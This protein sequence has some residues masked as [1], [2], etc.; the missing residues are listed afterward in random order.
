MLTL[1]LTI[2]NGPVLYWALDSSHNGRNPAV[3]FSLPPKAMQRSEASFG[4]PLTDDLLTFWRANKT[5]S[6]WVE[7]TEELPN[8]TFHTWWKGPISGTS[9]SADLLRLNITSSSAQLTRKAQVARLPKLR[10]NEL[11][12]DTNPE[13]PDRQESLP[14]IYGTV[15]GLPVLLASDPNYTEN[16]VFVIAGHPITSETVT[17]I[18]DGNYLGSYAVQTA[19]GSKGEYSYVQVPKSILG[20]QQSGLYLEQVTGKR[21]TIPDLLQ[22]LANQ[23]LPGEHKQEWRDM[24]TSGYA[25][26]YLKS[27]SLGMFLNQEITGD[28]LTAIGQ[29]LSQ[30]FPI[31][32]GFP[33]GKFSWCYTGVTMAPAIDDLQPLIYGQDLWNRSDLNGI[34]F[35]QVRNNFVYTAGFDGGTGREKLQRVL[36]RT[37]SAFCRVSAGVWGETAEESVSFPDVTDAGTAHLVAEEFAALGAKCPY[38]TSYITDNTDLLSAPIGKFFALQ[39][40]DWFTGNRLMRLDSVAYGS[41][42]TYELGVTVFQ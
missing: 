34:S 28:V 41:A 5:I 6:G 33:A 32:V 35:D 42:G 26:Q 2:K 18:L 36:N 15:Y 20:N 23:Y 14:E 29:R 12:E 24:V 10:I 27:F 39:D 21:F 16:L 9:A 31:Q 17:P 22:Y 19:T 25:A 3:D 11:L 37:N 1:E 7:V 40:S 8:G 30:S 4:L 38:T 13:T